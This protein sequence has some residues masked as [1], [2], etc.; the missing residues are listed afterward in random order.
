MILST[1]LLIRP[2][3]QRNIADRRYTLKLFHDDDLVDEIDFERVVEIE[4]D[5]R[6]IS[7]VFRNLDLEYRRIVI[8]LFHYLQ[9]LVNCYSFPA[10]RGMVL[11]YDFYVESIIFR[12]IDSFVKEVE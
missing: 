2:Y 11:V 9:T 10:Y 12:G 3:D 5:S 8:S 4:E 1:K 7:L 6:L